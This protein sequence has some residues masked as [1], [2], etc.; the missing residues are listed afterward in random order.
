[1]TST[2]PDLIRSFND[3]P[4]KQRSEEEEF[5]FL[6][7]LFGHRGQTW[8][9]LLQ[10]E[11]ILIVSEAGVGK[12]F[13][14]QAQQRKMWAAGE[15]A[16]FLELAVLGTTPLL[17]LFDA[18]ELERF[19]AWKAAES[20][21]AYFFLDSIDE[22]KL[23]ARSFDTTLKLFA[24]ALG[25]NLGRACIVLTAR[26]G[27]DD[28][29]VVRRR[30]PL[31][32]RVEVVAP[33][34][35]FLD[36]A[37]RV[38]PPEKDAAAERARWRYVGL[39]PLDKE[40]RRVLAI[41]QEV[42]DP[43]ALLAAIEVEHAEELAKRPLDFIAL[44][45]DWKE[46]ARI[47]GHR[48]QLETS[49]RIKLQ[50]RPATER[51]EW[52]DLTPEQ[53]R[54]GAERLALAALMTRR[55][56]LWHGK[57]ADRGSGD[58]ALDPREVLLNWS[59]L[60]VRTLLERALFG[61]ATYGRV[62][63]HS[64]TIIEYLTATRLHELYKDGLSL[65]TLHRMLFT[66][67][68]V[69][70]D[71]IRPTMEPVAA[72]LALWLEPI[73]TEILKRDPSVL[74]RAGD[75]GEL[76]PPQQALALERYV[77]RYGAGGWRGLHVPAVQCRRLASPALVPTIQ[78]LWAAG[79]E[80]SEVRETMLELVGTGQLK[81]C[82][83]IVHEAAA[84]PKGDSRE[85]LIGLEALAAL[86]D[87]RLSDLL[88][89][90]ET[91]PANWSSNLAANAIAV[92]FP[93]SMSV[94]Q[95]LGALKCVVYDPRGVGSVSRFLPDAITRAQLVPTALESLRHGL[96][97]LVEA[98]CRW[99]PSGFRVRSARGDLVGA[100]TRVCELQLRDDAPEA[101]LAH[102][103]ARVLQLCK[104][105]EYSDDESQA[106]RKLLATAPESLRKAVFWAQLQLL[107]GLMT[108][109]DAHARHYRMSTSPAMAL[110]VAQD[111][112]WLQRS[113][114]DTAH[115]VEARLTALE[116]VIDLAQATDDRL[117]TLEQT[118]PF[119]DGEAR[120]SARLEEMI[121]AFAN[122]P[123]QDAWL[124]ERARH[125]EAEQRKQAEHRAS[126]SEFWQDLVAEDGKPFAAENLV[127]TAHDLWKVMSGAPNDDRFAG[128]NRG[129]LERIFDKPLVERIRQVMVSTWRLDKPTLP[130]ERE[131]DQ[132]NWYY[133][134]WRVGLAGVFAEAEEEGWA[135]RLLPED[136]EL[137][138]RYAATALNGFPPWVADVA[139][140]HPQI[141]QQV[142]RPELDEQLGNTDP[143]AQHS[144]LLQYL[145]HA[146]PVVI[147]LF[148]EALREWVFPMLANGEAGKV[149]SNKFER[150]IELLL[151]HGN[152]SDRAQIKTAAQRFVRVNA[153]AEQVAFW[154]PWL[155]RLDPAE[156]V[157][158][159]EQLA[160]GIEPSKYSSV[161]RWL[162]AMFG[163][164]APNG[165]ATPALL[166]SPALLCRLTLLAY[167]HV[168]PT[169]DV[170]RMGVQKCEWN[171]RED[172]TYARNQ[173]LTAL[174]NAK[175]A[176]AWLAKL[177]FARDPLAGHFRDRALTMAKNAL[178][179]ESDASPYSV[180]DVMRLEKERDVA[181]IT[182][183][184]MA[185]LLS[186]RL[187][188]IDD[189]MRQD[190]SPR[191]T[192]ARVTSER[193]SRR[194]VTR[195]LKLL[196]KNAYSVTQEEV[197][198]EEKETDVRLHSNARVLQAAI[199]L[200]IGDKDYSYTDFSEALRDQLVGK[201]LVPEER[202]VGCLLI[203]LAKSRTW[204]HPTEGR[205][206]GID[207]VIALLRAEAADLVGALSFEALLQVRLLDLRPKE[208]PK[209]PRKA[210]GRG[211]AAAGASRS[212][213]TAD[214]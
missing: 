104:E 100:L 73:R 165:I 150:A 130:W 35:L 49:I 202:R 54:D 15:S 55:F 5:E 117:L 12:T 46:N 206:I 119:L 147:A 211:K 64:R 198:G 29:E 103:I 124:E 114:G 14:C 120:L 87:P 11:R 74:L 43:A 179:E 107:M 149:S 143:Q 58:G 20:E 142:L 160:E 22:F 82:A 169:D 53:A 34:Q 27:S 183:A 171:S 203:S 139:H 125:K 68:P 13:E 166:N 123:S 131:P 186:D 101:A 8:G 4:D 45:G 172:A 94:A 52:A 151:E 159:L 122:P 153:S 185:A 205:K 196:A 93:D 192:W 108:G 21:R 37:M 84:A 141:V 181:P 200:K 19:N 9:Q 187:D 144:T 28:R 78:R 127:G 167:R 161:T 71:L 70:V 66:T 148:L 195:E 3:L 77:A 164:H 111:L 182:R 60:Q 140:A 63:F 204:E 47:R 44:C 207:E 90:L 126:W 168:R 176:E 39:A 76:E 72:W 48:D 109:K 157:N 188:A 209:T 110:G 59:D 86:R 115:S 65:R 24:S 136:A 96:T 163:H 80:N 99:D 10:A 177:K 56:T 128:W 36:A 146:D 112:S 189:L 173:V 137:A 91:E 88:N 180:A 41:Q 79:I 138:M 132:R 2:V 105:D 81:D 40:Q 118:R 162:G 199:E 1:M 174:L 51:K 116:C 97:A 7:A 83:D 95:L 197:T 201:Y 31:S 17:E 16:F 170:L 61:Y 134:S 89:S 208:F 210:S 175:G 133:T 25:D 178:A 102:S 18:A 98:D 158:E 152:E 156:A 129:W 212:K 145:A 23:T 154:L 69:G 57:E 33:Q 32:E 135:R 26:P 155:M 191:E 42:P 67:T 50:P 121:H 113:L 85:R 92:L 194:L 106:L 62:R 6:Q 184:D 190:A 38:K 214:D 75:P 193:E 213:K 30:L